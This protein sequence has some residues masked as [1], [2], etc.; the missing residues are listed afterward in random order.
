MVKHLSTAMHKTIDEN[1]Y[2]EF[3]VAIICLNASKQL[4]FLMLNYW[5]NICQFSSFYLQAAHKSLISI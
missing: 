2:K 3:Q 4:L 5:K 1:T